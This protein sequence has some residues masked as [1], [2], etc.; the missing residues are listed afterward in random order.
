MNFPSPLYTSGT[1][2]ITIKYKQ[3]ILLGYP[4]PSS[5]EVD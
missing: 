4:S 5:S 3:D 1:K 2:A